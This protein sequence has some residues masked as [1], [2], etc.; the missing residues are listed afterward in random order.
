MIGEKEGDRGR[1]IK[2][3]FLKNIFLFQKKIELG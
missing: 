3:N 2:F 1:K